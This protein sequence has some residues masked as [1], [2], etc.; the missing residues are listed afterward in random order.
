MTDIHNAAIE[1]IA[2]LSELADLCKDICKLNESERGFVYRKL[3]EAYQFGRVDFKL[4]G[5]DEND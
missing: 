3:C 4:H 5:D 2:R 1:R